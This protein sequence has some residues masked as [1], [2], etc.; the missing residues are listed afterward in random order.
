[1]RAPR[2]RICL[3]KF[4]I[5]YIGI[6]KPLLKEV[7]FSA[8]QHGHGGGCP[9]HP[10]YREGGVQHTLLTDLQLDGGDPAFSFFSCFIHFIF[11]HLFLVFLKFLFFSF[12]ITGMHG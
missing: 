4:R 11:I 2:A 1:M 10:P 9:T 3:Y 5:T 8:R 12:V 6:Y 7:F